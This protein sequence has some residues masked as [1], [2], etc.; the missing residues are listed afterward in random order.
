MGQDYLIFKT[1]HV[2][3]FKFLLNSNQIMWIV[4]FNVCFYV[5]R[6]FSCDYSKSSEDFNEEEVLHEKDLSIVRGKALHG[7][8]SKFE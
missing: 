6:N 7:I 1:Y 5:D 8:F 2:L 3:C 4:I